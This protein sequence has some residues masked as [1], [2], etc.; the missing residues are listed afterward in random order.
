M[1]NGFMSTVVVFF[2]DAI[3][4]IFIYVWVSLVYAECAALISDV[5]AVVAHD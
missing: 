3:E 4:A 2:E 5:G 1:V